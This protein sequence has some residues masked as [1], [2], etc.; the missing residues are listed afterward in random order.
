MAETQHTLFEEKHTPWFFWILVLTPYLMP[1]FWKYHVVLT[2]EYL[3]IGYSSSC[4]KRKTDKSQI[5]SMEAI[6]H[7]K[8]V[9]DWGG[10]G[11]RKKLS[12]WETGYIARNGPG[13]R[14][15]FLDSD[16]KEK[17]VTFSCFDPEKLVTLLDSSRA[18][19]SNV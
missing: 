8:G 9:I 12:T 5:L 17:Y 3:S 14:M 6:P 13:I 2:E 11:I 1:F 16:G 18:L 10:Y 4:V 19:R 15:R 7:I